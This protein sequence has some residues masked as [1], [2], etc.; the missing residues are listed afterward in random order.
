MVQNEDKIT[1]YILSGEQ[2]YM[3]YTPYGENKWY[4]ISVMNPEIMDK[5]LHKINTMVWKLLVEVLGIFVLTFAW[6]FY[7]SKKK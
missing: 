6:I 5:K 2:R 3:H 1:P 4:T 7:L